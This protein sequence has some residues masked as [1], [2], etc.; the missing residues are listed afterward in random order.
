MNPVCFD[1]SIP[2]ILI[3]IQNNY[4]NRALLRQKQRALSRYS[5]L[6][7][8]KL[9]APL[10][11]ILSLSQ[12]INETNGLD[13]DPGVIKKLLRDISLQAESLDSIIYALND[14]ITKD[15]TP[16]REIRELSEKKIDT[17]MLIDDDPIVNMIHE[18][19]LANHWS[20][21]TVKTFTEALSALDVM[22]VNLPDLILLDIN[23]PVMNG[24]QFLQALEERR[25][26]TDVIM[27]SSS[28]DPEEKRRAFT[29]KNVKF[30]LN[31]PLTPDLLKSVLLQ[32]V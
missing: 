6:T 9:R 24:W 30:F 31:K 11:N 1:E 12:S 10:S 22:I 18:K 16:K 7:S 4:R 21:I 5:F 27:V 29:F 19:M 15:N 13:Y 17:I 26:N 20:H 14:L 25:V 8:H 2:Y 23:M 32:R 3:V 28:I